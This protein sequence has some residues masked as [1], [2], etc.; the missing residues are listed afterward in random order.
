MNTNQSPAKLAVVLSRKKARFHESHLV[1][2]RNDLQGP[3]HVRV[4]SC[5]FVVAF[6]WF[7][8][9]LCANASGLLARA[10]SAAGAHQPG[11]MKSEFI[12][13]AAPFASSHASTIV[14]TKEGPVAAWFG[15]PHE[16]H[17]EVV[18]WTARHDGK[19]WSAP[20]QVADGIQE[21]GRTR[22]PCWNP[23]LFQPKEGPLL[24]F[25][26]VGPN[27]CQTA[28]SVRFATSRCSCR[29]VHCFAAPAPKT[30]AGESTWNT[31]WTW[32]QPGSARR[33]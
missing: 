24:L 2:R 15:G 3:N 10:A 28:R 12:F 11:L 29:T 8:V 31:R 32:A 14:E 21:D 26:K 9:L 6:F 16:R 20:A 27:V 17:P 4:H 25:F 13:D 23:V 33:R 7:P 18:I 22:Y 19:K 5:P 1:S 30:A